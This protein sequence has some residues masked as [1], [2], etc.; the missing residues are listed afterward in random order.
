MGS[1]QPEVESVAKR[2]SDALGAILQE[3]SSSRAEAKSERALRVRA[4][5]NF[6]RANR[7]ALAL[8]ERA[9]EALEEERRQQ[10]R[11]QE[12]K[13]EDRRKRRDSAERARERRERRE[14]IRLMIE[15]E[16]RLTATRNRTRK[17]N[18]LLALTVVCVVATVALLFV[19]AVRRE[20]LILGGSAFT[21]LLSMAGGFLIRSMEASGQAGERFVGRPSPP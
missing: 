12:L 3:Q 6:D 13:A 5:K 1:P 2:V 9:E 4:V 21:G 17:E 19:T 8:I 7:R 18:V 11:Q 10:H 15:A 20:P 16:E 14:D